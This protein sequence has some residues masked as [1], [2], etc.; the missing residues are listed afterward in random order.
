VNSQY[1]RDPG[2]RMNGSSAWERKRTGLLDLGR[3]LR[4]VVVAGESLLVASAGA[5]DFS[6]PQPPSL[7]GDVSS[8]WCCVGVLNTTIKHE[9]ER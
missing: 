9:Q 3:S 1:R 7:S 6:L 2:V 4:C 8:L 5:T